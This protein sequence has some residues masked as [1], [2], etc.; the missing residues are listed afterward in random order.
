MASRFIL[1]LCNQGIL[2]S[3]CRALHSPTREAVA[4]GDILEVLLTFASEEPCLSSVVAEL[5]NH[6]TAAPPGHCHL[7][8]KNTLCWRRLISYTHQF[9]GHQVKKK[10]HSFLHSN[11]I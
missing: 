4:S 2:I 11:R 5:V 3:D 6:T 9:E 1:S 8:A 7:L 10:K